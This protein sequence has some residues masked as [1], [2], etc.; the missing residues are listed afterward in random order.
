MIRIALRSPRVA[1]VDEA[2]A[3]LGSEPD[4][5]ILAAV[6]CPV[7]LIDD[8]TDRML[9]LKPSGARKLHWRDLTM[10]SGLRE[11]AVRSINAVEVDHVVVVR[12]EAS[13]E[14]LERRRRLCMQRLVAELEIR[15]VT[16]MIAESRGRADDQRDVDHFLAMRSQ[17]MPGSQIRIT[18][19]AGPSNAAL[20]AADIVA[21]T[22]AADLNGDKRP[23]SM[24]SALTVIR[25]TP[26]RANP[27]P[28]D[29]T[30]TPGVHF[31]SRRIGR[32]H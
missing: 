22:V 9:A 7:A 10:K 28:R 11:I 26:S 13:S 1:F 17:K 2:T 18:H 21:G 4:T 30:G 8:L 23:A 27:G 24:L 32:R 14:R 19:E 29:D 25:I 16:D 12:L 3:R 15:G 31:H 6:V 5:Y 20:W